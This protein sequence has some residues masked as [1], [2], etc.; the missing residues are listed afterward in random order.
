MSR[1]IKETVLVLLA[2]LTVFAFNACK[3]PAAETAEKK[4]RFVYVS[5]MLSHPWFIQEEMGIIKAAQELGIDYVGIDSNLSDEKCLADID[6]VFSMN[7]DALLLVVT[8]QSMG[9]NIA[10]RCREEGVEL[11]T[12]DD[13]IVD[14]FG[15]PV[16]HVGMPTKESGELGGK[17]L[18]ELAVKRNF[19]A[20][21]NVVKVFQIDVP[22]TTVFAPRVDGYREALMANSPLGAGDFIRVDT[23][24]GMY[25]DN[26]EVAAP[27][28]LGNPN[29]TH[30]IITGAND[31]CALAPM[32]VL[33]EQGFNMDNVLACGL[34]GYEMSLEEFKN[35]NKNYICIVLG[36]D[37]EG[38][39]AVKIL[40]DKIVNGTEMPATTLV[41]GSIA[42]SENYL[43][44]FPNGKLMTDQ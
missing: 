37:E 40:Y 16:P 28:I 35:G 17:A 13:N 26:L 43:T 20:P 6:S 12:I 4:L 10:E 31:D 22:T 44:Y 19:F 29:V 7:A 25:E 41:A 8:N 38:Y 3:K 30:W 23:T 27:V 34:G 24:E 42:D 21:G 11:V 2:L 1:K 33:E 9:P 18:A 39:Q 14:E 32:T 5:K 15:N 36:P